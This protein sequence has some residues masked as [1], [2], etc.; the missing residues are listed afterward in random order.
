MS[1]PHVERGR[2]PVV[3]SGGGNDT[4]PRELVEPRGARD[5][6]FSCIVDALEQHYVEIWKEK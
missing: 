2:P 3:F 4:R 5:I 1:Q 6:D